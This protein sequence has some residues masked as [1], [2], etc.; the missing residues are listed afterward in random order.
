MV[1]DIISSG[2]YRLNLE[3]CQRPSLC[4]CSESNKT[5]NLFPF[6][7]TLW[8][9]EVRINVVRP[10]VETYFEPPSFILTIV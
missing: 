8:W 2:S 1:N 4:V 7:V 10:M 9:N 5:P 3:S 6:R